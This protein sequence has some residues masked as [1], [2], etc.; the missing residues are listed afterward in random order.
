MSITHVDTDLLQQ[1]QDQMQ[2][3]IRHMEECAAILRAVNNQMMT[4]DPSLSRFAQWDR[5]MDTC[6]QARRKAEQL[7]ETLERFHQVIAGAS[8]KYTQM[9]QDHVRRIEALTAQMSSL[10][11]GMACVMTLEY[12]TGLAEGQSSSSAIALER[13]V[14]LGLQSMEITNLMAVTQILEDEMGVTEVVGDLVTPV[15]PGLI[16]DGTDGEEEE[17]GI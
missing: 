5:A 3:A 4:E 13:Q 8:Q 11:Y 12:P 9:D 14:S 1:V 15:T 2:R 10:H 6:S 7:T 17:T 16:F